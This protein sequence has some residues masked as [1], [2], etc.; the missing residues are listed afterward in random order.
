M[1][2]TGGDRRPRIRPFIQIR[3]GLVPA[4][5][6]IGQRHPNVTILGVGVLYNHVN[7][8]N[9]FLWYRHSL[10]VSYPQWNSICFAGPCTPR[11]AACLLN[12]Q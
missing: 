7:F 2:S 10:S 3:G 8:V 4:I 1:R 5:D 6:Q 9:A 12:N 11:G